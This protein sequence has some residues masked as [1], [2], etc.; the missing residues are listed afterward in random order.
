MAFHHRMTAS[1][2]GIRLRAPVEWRALDGILAVHWQ[3]EGEKDAGGYYLSPD[4]RIMIF[5]DDVAQHIRMTSEGGGLGRSCR[6]MGRVIYVPAGVPLWS[7][8]V[9]RHRF[10]H[11]DLHMH[12]RALH[13]MLAPRLGGSAALAAVRTPRMLEDA[14]VV[15]PLAT[16]LTAEIA[17]PAHHDLYAESLVQSIAAAILADP[18]PAPIN[19]AAGGLSGA[20]MRRLHGYLAEN[21]HRRVT[22]AELAAEAGLSE[23]WFAHAFK[24]GTGETPQQWQ[25]RLRVERA[26]ECMA[27]S[28]D[29]LSAISQMLGFADQAH[30]TRVFRSLTGQTPA[31]WRRHHLQG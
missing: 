23:S 18:C 7:R 2:D 16:L 5:F 30:L 8:F 15:E 31:A 24:H 10:R 29:S 12:G 26:Q 20:Q 6:P 1:V 19:A 4:P 13:D 28:H 27:N 22:N 14:G 3:A 21:M 9:G 11:L 25:A 17:A